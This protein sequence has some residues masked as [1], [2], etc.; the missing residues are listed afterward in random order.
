MNSAMASIPTEKLSAFLT[1]CHRV[2][3]YGLLKCSSG[4]LS[5]RLDEE[6]VMITATRSWLADLTA[7]QVSLLRLSDGALLNEAKPSVETR[8]HLG[9]LRQRRDVNVVLHFQSTAATTLTC[10]DP[11]KINFF[12]IPEIP[13]YIGPIAVLPYVDPGSAD[14]AAALVPA[15]R[16]HN[17]AILTGHGQ[18]TVGRDYNEALQRA[19]FFELAC[20]IIVRGGDCV[21]PLGE[22]AVKQLL[23]SSSSNAVV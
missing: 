20:D 2:A 1:A 6:R 13:Y 23:N 21:Q 18:V 14:L 12:V 16:D 15:M 7:D 19:V 22:K 3:A 8:F 17:L 11:G 5:C 4:N 10:A 9:I